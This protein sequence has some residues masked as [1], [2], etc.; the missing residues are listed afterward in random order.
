MSERFELPNACSVCGDV[1]CDC[2]LSVDGVLEDM[3]AMWVCIRDY[4]DRIK[5]LDAE[6]KRLAEMNGLSMRGWSRE[7]RKREQ[8]EA[9]LSQRDELLDEIRTVVDSDDILPV[10]TI[11]RKLANFAKRKGGGD[12]SV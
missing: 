11:R 6:N 12:G 3:Q 10:G 8:A 2:D 7:N 4:E 5:E 9:K 1:D